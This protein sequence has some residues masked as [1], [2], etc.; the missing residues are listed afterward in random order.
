MLEYLIGNQRRDE[1]EVSW[2]KE[3]GKRMFLETIHKLSRHIDKT[4]QVLTR[5]DMTWHDKAR[6][7][8]FESILFFDYL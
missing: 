1:S 3:K 6:Q 5:H 4:R 8:V 2:K 7:I